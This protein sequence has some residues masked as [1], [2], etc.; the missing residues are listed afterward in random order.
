MLGTV[1]HREGSAPSL[2]GQLSPP[3]W[4]SACRDDGKYIGWCPTASGV[5]KKKCL[6]E[7]LPGRIINVLLKTKIL[8]CVAQR[9]N[10]STNKPLRENKWNHRIFLTTTFFKKRKEKDSSHGHTSFGAERI[11]PTR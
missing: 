8:V 3:T 1:G 6:R 10:T 9:A 11:F 2:V 7:R 5:V 4:Q